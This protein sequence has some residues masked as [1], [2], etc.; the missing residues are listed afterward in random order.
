MPAPRHRK[1]GE[2]KARELMSAQPTCCT[3]GDTVQEA[4]RLMCE[5]DCGCIPV[6]EDKKSNRIVGVITDRDIAC[7]CTAQGKGPKTSVKEVMTRD[8][9]C[10]A[11][12][13]EVTLVE[14]IMAEEQVRRVPVVDDRGFCVGIIAQADLALN[15]RAASDSEVG[16]VVERISE[17]AHSSGSAPVGRAT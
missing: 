10:C 7:R 13:D 1:E 2:V 4:A 9:K 14:R 3:P 11:P 16:K 5:C 8:P 6:V 17:P 12:D 15:A